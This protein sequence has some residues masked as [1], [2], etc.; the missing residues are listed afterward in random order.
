MER[1][2]R[3][4]LA[5]C[6]ETFPEEGVSVLSVVDDETDTCIFMVKNEEADRLYEYLT[7][8]EKEME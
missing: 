2:I 6:Y 3:R 1:K 8:Y 5:L 7:Q 4:K